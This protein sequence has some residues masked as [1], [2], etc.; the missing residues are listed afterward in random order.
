MLSIKRQIDLFKSV[1]T[2]FNQGNLVKP[3]FEI[4]D[5]CVGLHLKDDIFDTLGY[6]SCTTPKSVFIC[7]NKIKEYSDIKSLNSCIVAEIVAIHEIAHYIHFNL[8]GPQLFCNEISKIHK[9][10]V[11]S[12]AQLL[13][14]RVCKDLSFVHIETFE[15]MKQGQSL[16][17]TDY[18]RVIDNIGK[19]ICSLPWSILKES[20]INITELPND[21]YEM[22]S[23]KL[24]KYLNLNY[25]FWFSS[26][27]TNEENLR[28]TE[29][30]LDG[31]K[32]PLLTKFEEKHQDSLTPFIN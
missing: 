4:T 27:F 10:F 9:L 12:F 11:E 17:Y 26:G 31:D 19:P 13:T 14:H 24:E 18:C 29:L 1:I 32:F 3:N 2:Y 25:P 7:N 23:F 6:F 8:L 22:I 21:L 28:L 16:E 30:G 5:N 20:F 15:K